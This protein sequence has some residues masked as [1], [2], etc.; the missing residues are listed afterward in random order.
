[1]T[2]RGALPGFDAARCR[3]ECAARGLGFG[4][5]I[6]HQ[7]VTDSTNDDALALA[8]SGAAHGVVVIA[9]R[10]TQGRGRRGTRWSSAPGAGLLFSLIVRTRY[11]TAQFSVLPLV[12][13]LAVRQVVAERVSDP[14]LVKWPNDVMVRSRKICGVLVESYSQAGEVRALVVG[15]GLNVY[16]EP[17]PPEIADRAVSLEALGASELAREP[18]LADVLAALEQRFVE[19]ASHGFVAS[20]AEFARFDFLSGRSVTVGEHS[21]IARGIAEN[22]ALILECDGVERQLVAGT[23]EF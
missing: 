8:K 23:V 11:E 20:H 12:V 14:A 9:D 3:A 2:E 21:G 1:M 15:V 19:L 16:Q 7:A 5:R 13:G 6:E 4:A 10:Q 17:L 22:G 18:L